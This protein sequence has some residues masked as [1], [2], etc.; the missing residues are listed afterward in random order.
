MQQAP[1]INLSP[2]TDSVNVL[3]CNYHSFQ[4]L[5][6]Q[7]CK[8]STSKASIPIVG[9]TRSHIGTHTL[10]PT[11]ASLRPLTHFPH[12]NQVPGLLMLSSRLLYCDSAKRI[13][14]H[15]IATI[16]L[17]MLHI[18]CLKSVNTVTIKQRESGSNVITTLGLRATLKS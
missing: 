10:S 18:P 17:V 8:K 11:S 2:Q 5:P 3:L 16:P 1:L 12:L 14:G 15:T 9:P 6:H 13:R 4:T 7:S